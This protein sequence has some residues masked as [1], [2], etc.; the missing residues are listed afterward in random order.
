MSGARHGNMLAASNATRR[1]RRRFYRTRHSNIAHRSLSHAYVFHLII[2]C[3]LRD[4]LSPYI[5]TVG[6]PWSSEQSEYREARG[7]LWRT[8]FA[9]WVR[10]ARYLSLRQLMQPSLVVECFTDESGGIHNKLYED[11]DLQVKLTLKEQ[12]KKHDFCAASMG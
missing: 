6:R 1:D 2:T 3:A 4:A 8:W 7:L 5:Q 11:L 9:E 12:S 10:A